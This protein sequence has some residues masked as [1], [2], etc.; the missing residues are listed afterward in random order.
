MLNPYFLITLLFIALAG[1]GA[2]DSALTSFALLP[3]FNGLRWLRVHLITLGILVEAAFG[4]LPVLVAARSKQPRPAIRWDI[5]LALNSGL[6]TLLVAIPLVNQP[7][8]L[9]GGAL[10]FVAAGL[11]LHQLA[12]LLPRPFKLQIGRGGPFYLAGLGCLLVGITVGT[13]LWLGW[14]AVLQ[15]ARP[16]EV[17]IHANVWGFGGLL[18]AG[19]LVDLG[20]GLTGKPLARPDAVRPIF[21][22]MTTGAVLL[23]IGPWVN[24]N[25]VMAAGMVMQ[26]AATVWLLANLFR[27]VWQARWPVGLWHLLAAY[28][29]VLALIL[30]SPLVLVGVPGV[31][32]E[33]VEQS[34]PQSLIYGWLLQF[35]YALLPWLFGR[36]FQPSEPARLGGNW[37]SLAAVNLGTALLWA[38]I[39]VAAWQAPLHGLAYAAWFISVLPVAIQLWQIVRRAM[40][41][42]AGEVLL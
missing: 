18:L 29:W 12:G 4:L 19:L 28:G 34:A 41:L 39:F 7:L 16:A 24:S 27:P 21:W 3:W 8:I 37:L 30:A 35:S 1:L 9:V 17:H 11:L 32:R 22:M 20:P 38:G 5:W 25:P 36:F 6:L 33:A 14:G 26:M 40:T 13:G 31:S 10:V 15:I 42:D 2:L 23:I